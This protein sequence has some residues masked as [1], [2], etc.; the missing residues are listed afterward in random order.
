M[1]ERFVGAVVVLKEWYLA[2]VADAA[3]QKLAVS[4]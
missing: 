4:D 3:Y 2:F 1:R